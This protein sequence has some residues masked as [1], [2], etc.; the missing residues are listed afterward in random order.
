VELVDFTGESVVKVRLF[1]ACASYPMSTITLEMGIERTLLQHL[2]QLKE[3]CGLTDC[4][5]R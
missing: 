5:G 1:G 4:L 3:V 2:P